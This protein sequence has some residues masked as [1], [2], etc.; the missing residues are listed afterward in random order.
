MELNLQFVGDVLKVMRSDTKLAD[1]PVVMLSSVDL[2]EADETF[3]ELGANASLSKPAR[4]ELLQATLE[5]VIGG[6]GTGTSSKVA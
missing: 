6:P 4:S 5:Q 2:A 3:T 1:V